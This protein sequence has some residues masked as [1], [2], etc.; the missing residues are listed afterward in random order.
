MT[1]NNLLQALRLN[2]LYAERYSFPLG[3][4]YEESKIPYS[5][6]RFIQKGRAVFAIDGNE[7]ALQPDDLVYIPQGS[8]LFCEAM[9][10][11]FTFISIRYTAAFPLSEREVWSEIL[12]IDPV[13]RCTDPEIKYYFNCIIREK[14]SA[15]RGR[16]FL[17]RGYLELILAYL[18]DASEAFSG[19]ERAKRR[20]LTV[21]SN[22]YDNRIQVILDYMMNNYEKEM[23][24]EDLSA[25]VKL[26]PSS[27]R[28][29]FKQHTGKTPSEFL[30]ELK[31]V[32]AAKKILETDERISDIAYMVGIEDPNYFSRRF[33]KHYGVTPHSYRQLAR[34]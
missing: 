25:M 15:K 18:I 22:K 31:M 17:L 19:G 30:T 13:V 14:N 5:M 7:Y 29:L 27:L 26:S 23:S 9:T 4:T 33:K 20:T 6:I 12:G 32:V 3:W 28:R 10:D 21:D 16:Y 34:D 2:F 8:R 11:D 1:D 24:M